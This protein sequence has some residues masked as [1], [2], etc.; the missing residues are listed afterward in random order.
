MNINT[1]VLAGRLTRDVDMRHTQ[2]GTSIANIGLALNRRVKRGDDWVDEPVF[3]DVKLWGKRAEAFA[4]YHSKGSQACF[5]KCELV[6]E[7]WEKEGEK[8]SK[9]VVH[10]ECWEF[11]GPKQE[12][13]A[14][15][16]EPAW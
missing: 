5:P 13:S 3:V 10:A 14:G 1:V 8:R 9:L 7:Q 15:A 11:C 16:D 2:T 4:Q 6:L 12:K